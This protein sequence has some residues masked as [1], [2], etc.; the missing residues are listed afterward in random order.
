MRTGM[1]RIG[2][3]PHVAEAVINHLPSKLERT[4]NRD[5]M[6]ASKRAALVAWAEH[7]AL[8][9]AKAAADNV[10]SLRSA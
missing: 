9:V 2:V 1:S 3:L 5:A 10:V 7:V 6:E 8:A 4:Y